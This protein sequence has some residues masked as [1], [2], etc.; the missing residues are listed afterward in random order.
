MLSLRLEKRK[1][2][3]L[4]HSKLWKKK[5]ELSD[6]SG[7]RCD[8]DVEIILVLKKSD[9]KHVERVSCVVER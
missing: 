1:D 6:S 7:L 4:I 8:E 3:I 2:Q 9:L 5:T